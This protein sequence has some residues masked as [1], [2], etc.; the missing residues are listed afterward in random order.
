MQKDVLKHILD[1]MPFPVVFVD[2]DHMIRFMNRRAEYHY[3]QERGFRNLIGTSI[4]E[5]HND[6][7]KERILQIVEKLRNH[8]RELL[9]AVN[10]KNER[11][12]VTPVRDGKGEFI[13]YFERFEGNYQR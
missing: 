9:L 13:G 8:G 3:Y 5:C 11:V 7:S 12:Y 6:T 2:T 1:A 10:E 4:F